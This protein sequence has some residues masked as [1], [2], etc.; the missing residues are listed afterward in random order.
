MQALDSSKN[1][2][3]NWKHGVTNSTC[4]GWVNNQMPLN[5]VELSYVKEFTANLLVFTIDWKL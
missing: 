5:F 1:Y 2:V 3:I 4:H